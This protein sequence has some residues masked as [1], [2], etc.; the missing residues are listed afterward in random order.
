MNMQ[1]DIETL[2]QAAEGGSHPLFADV[3]A[4]MTPAEQEIFNSTPYGLA[5]G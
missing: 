2:E 4:E 3:P 5:A 1:P